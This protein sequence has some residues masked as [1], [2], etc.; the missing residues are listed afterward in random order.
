MDGKSPAPFITLDVLRGVH[1]DVTECK[2]PPLLADT[3]E[4]ERLEGSVDIESKFIRRVSDVRVETD[5]QRKNGQTD[6]HHFLCLRPALY[7]QPLM[8]I[9]LLATFGLLG[10]MKRRRKGCTR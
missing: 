9:D 6:F 4:V 1:L 10:H 8:D 5:R 3:T 2:L 7:R